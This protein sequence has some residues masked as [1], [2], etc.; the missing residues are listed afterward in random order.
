VRRR[1]GPWQ[2]VA[3][4][5]VLLC[6][7][8]LHYIGHVARPYALLSLL[9]A[10]IAWLLMR[11]AAGRR[12]RFVSI[13]ICT[14]RA[15]L[16]HYTATVAIGAFAL[17]LLLRRRPRWSELAAI[18][19]GVAVW[20][21][22]MGYCLTVIEP[23]EK[24]LWWLPPAN[25][26]SAAT[27][28]TRFT[29]N[30]NLHELTVLYPSARAALHIAP[31]VIALLVVYGAVRGGET[32]RMLLWLW[33]GPMAMGLYA[34]VTGGNKD[35][36]S[37]ERYFVAAILAQSTLVT[38]AVLDPPRRIAAARYAAGPLLVAVV[39]AGFAVA[40][41]SPKH[42]YSTRE[43]ARHVERHI[44][45]NELAVA[46]YTNQVFDW[47]HDGEYAVLLDSEGLANPNVP[48]MPMPDALLTDASGGVWIVFNHE[49]W[50]RLKTGRLE[51]MVA[52]QL[53]ALQLRFPNQRVIDFPHGKLLHLRADAGR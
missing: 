18:A 53:A 47:Y 31:A 37:T 46:V 44:G 5:A 11:E 13:A 3:V 50:Q 52:D 2:A 14:G 27:A 24:N 20:L 40:M 41:S 23:V 29:L 6:N 33:V 39:V 45:P 7:A 17:F 48:V 25:W 8:S 30:F 35:L 28:I 16:T 38:L 42:P 1:V 12:C 19:T 9:V 4:L 26:P 34:V 21:P 49:D 43:M 36:F 10:G 51:E 32:G 22:W 15:R